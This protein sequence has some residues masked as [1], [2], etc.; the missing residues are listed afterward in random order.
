MWIVELLVVLVFI[1]FGARLGSIGIGFAGGFGVLVLGLVF[2]L[3]PGTIPVDVILI[4]MGVISAI[5]AMQVAG[6]LD[7]LVQ[8]ATKV[9][10]S[11]PQY[12]T[13]I[14]PMV[15]YS[16]TM[17]AGTGLT[18]FSTLPVIA[19]VAKTAGV[20]P[21]RPLA[22]STVASQIAITASP[23]SAAVVFFSG[24]LEKLG[25]DYLQ[26]LMVV[27]PST[28]IA[29][30]LGAFV[31]NFLG[32]ELKDDPIY[33]ERL[34]KGQISESKIDDNKV[35]PPEAKRSVLIFG[36][37]LICVLFYATAISPTAGL[38]KNPV[39]GR[40]HAIITFMLS[41]AALITFFC[42]IEAKNIL[43]AATFKSGMS[44]CICVLGVAWL[45]TTFVTA[46]LEEINVLAGTILETKPWLLAVALFFGSMLLYSQAATTK[47]L[48]PVAL[49]LG[50]SPAAAIAAFPAVCALFVLPTYPTLLASVEFDDTGST[51]IGKYVLNHSF[52]IPGTLT[53]AFAVALGF[54]FGGLFL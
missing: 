1:W 15:T 54:V 16:M 33:Q 8:I 48:M 27:I 9:L 46:H 12:I 31:T 42:K 19:E 23:I 41:A 29:V 18:A 25:T 28:F 50:V 44:S 6:G 53:I 52:I 47:A 5:A 7:Y 14:A 43:N 13:F 51:K 32:K 11:K 37:A 2:G 34:A 26:L 45:G 30:M 40:D 35:L 36:F 39:I 3:K 38:I 20:R 22:I 21:S 49:A 4:I 17:F 10:K 24:A